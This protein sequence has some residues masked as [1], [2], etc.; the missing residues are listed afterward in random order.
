MNLFDSLVKLNT[1]IVGMVVL[2]VMALTGM[3]LINP[4]LALPLAKNQ[5]VVA[6]AYA[7]GPAVAPVTPTPTAT[8][9]PTPIPVA[10]PIHISI[11]TLGVEADIE[12]V[13]VSAE[14]VMEIPH[15]FLKVGWYKN[16]MKPGQKGN[17]AAII[18]GHYDTSTGKPAVFFHIQKLTQNDEIII[19]AED[20]IRYVFKIHDVQS[21]PLDNFPTDIVYGV[22]NGTILKIITCDG[23]WQPDKN[24]YSDRLVVTSH[25][26]RIEKPI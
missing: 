23:Y 7:N 26:V 13:G 1:Y 10:N 8:P 18:N 15:D 4:D 12:Q 6:G 20:R 14:N 16:S 21:H 11:P 24:S 25:L 19:T 22:T 5:G 9:T 17:T 2:F 3:A